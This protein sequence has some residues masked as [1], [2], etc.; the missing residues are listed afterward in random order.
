MVDFEKAFDTVEHDTLW[1]A[2][3]KQSVR[4][5][6]VDLLKRLYV[7]QSACVSAGVRSRAFS[8]FRGVKQGDPISSFLFVVVMEQIFRSL[9]RRW[10]SLNARRT[11][12]YYGIVV[13]D[14]ADTLSNLRFAD[15]V[16]LLS[17]NKRDVGRMIV[18]LD[19]EAKKYG[20]KM[21]MGKTVVVT[22]SATRPATIR[23]SGNDVR[24]MQPGETEKYLGRE[25]TLDDYHWEELNNRISSA[26][27]SFCCQKSILCNRHVPLRDRMRLFHAT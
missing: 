27:E 5:E 6:Y 25:F 24:V 18:D 17:S 4:P 14:A 21:H 20:L 3:E 8:I 19:T 1:S 11:G 16:L 13:D 9:K 7:V 10:G 23:C 2:L 22:N 12:E 26:W 15:D